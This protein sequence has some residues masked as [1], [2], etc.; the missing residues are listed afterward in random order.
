[1][2]SK[3]MEL[4]IDLLL[5]ALRRR[6]GY[7]FNNYSRSVVRRVLIDHLA[8]CECRTVSE[9]IPRALYD[10]SFFN[11][12]MI[13]L[14]NTVTEM[15]RDPAF[16]CDVRKVAIPYL[17]SYPF[18]KVWHAGCST[19]EEVYS[20]AILFHEEGLLDR[21]QFY[22]TDF[23]LKALET[24]KSGCYQ[25]TRLKDYTENYN[26]SGG[27]ASFSEYYSA[28]HQRGQLSSSLRKNI[29]FAHHDLVLDGSL[30]EMQMVVCRNVLIY[31][32]KQLRSQVMAMFSNSLSHDGLLCL[33]RDESITFSGIEKQ[34]KTLSPENKI[35]LKTVE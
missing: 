1:M 34:F 26:Q 5:E 25:L 27:K 12:L 23:N 6:Y 10:R 18:I 20:M 16:Y 31:F 7:D 11:R 2:D 3:I 4:E 19:G 14:S 35:Y 21:T 15:F 30:G 33:G 17:K 22:A 9:F 8:K 13:G 32:D 24:A 28:T 29:T